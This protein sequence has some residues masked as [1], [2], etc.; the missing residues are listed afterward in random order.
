VGLHEH[1]I[2]RDL[3]QEIFIEPPA[4]DQAS[5]PA[6]EHDESDGRD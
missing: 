5:P 2:A 1:V 4:I 6:A 3:A